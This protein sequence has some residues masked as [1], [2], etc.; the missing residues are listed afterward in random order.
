MLINEMKE[1]KELSELLSSFSCEKDEDIE[2]FLHKRAIEF[3][4]LSKA[5]TYLVFDQ[6]QLENKD[7]HLIIY[8]NLSIALK[9]LSVPQDMSNHMRKELDGFSAKRHGELISDFPCYLIGQLSKNSNVKSGE[10]TGKQLIDFASDIIATSVEAVGGRYM[11]VEC[12][13]EEK[14][15]KLYQ[16]N[17]FN[18]IA[19]IPD[20]NQPMVQMIRKIC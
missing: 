17:Y 7:K 12:R 15:I 4:K 2:Y 3:E 5:R 11:M 14:L 16:D 6:E 20:E 19:R 13:D 10:V 8:G 1:G 18:E 9:I